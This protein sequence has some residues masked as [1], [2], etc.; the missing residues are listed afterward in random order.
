MTRF[1]KFVRPVIETLLAGLFV[2]YVAAIIVGLSAPV[3]IGTAPGET[4]EAHAFMG[5]VFKND[6]A[7]QASLRP[8]RD[9][10]TRALELKANAQ[11][12]QNVDAKSLTYLGGETRGRLGIHMYALGYSASAG[13]VGLV[14]FTL[15]T[16]A[17][18]VLRVV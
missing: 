11:G 18:R 10:I 8:D 17:G 14:P 4:R 15:T 12:R 6:L 13:E 2:G 5:A 7:A 3:A 9:P 1:R 16:G